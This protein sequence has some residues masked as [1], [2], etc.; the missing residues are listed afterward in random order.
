MHERTMRAVARS[1]FVACCA[2][3]T[4]VTMLIILVLWSPWYHRRCVLATEASLA[5]QTGLD[6]RIGSLERVS[7]T[8]WQLGDVQLRDNETKQSIGRIRIVSWVQE[9]NR[10]VVR[11]S[12]PEIRAEY[13]DDVWQLVHDRF[14]CRP[15]HTMN[16]IRLAADDLTIQSAHSQITIRDLDGTILPDEKQVTAML[17]CMLAGERPDIEPMEIEIKR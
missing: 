15:E 10:T 11:L 7:P 16:P 1:L 6:V 9:D 17:S 4:C 2:V 13:L 8:T 5:L 3:P 12:Q 14:L